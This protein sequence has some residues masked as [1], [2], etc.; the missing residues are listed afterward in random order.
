MNTQKIIKKFRK[1]FIVLNSGQIIVAED[2]E[3]EEG[4]N[5]KIIEPKET[6][7][8]IIDFIS[9]TYPAYAK[10][11]ANG[12]LPEEKETLP[13]SG[14]EGYDKNAGFNSAIAEMRG[15]INKEIK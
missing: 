1:E 9:T 12:C 5:G 6:I 7:E 14:K 15:N 4:Q 13:I 2:L 11:F 8:K 10:E 3:L